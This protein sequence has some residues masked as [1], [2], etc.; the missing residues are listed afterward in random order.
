MEA[1]EAAGRGQQKGFFGRV[2]AAMG[3]GPQDPRQV[4]ASLEME[5]SSL[6]RL[7]Q[8]L[9]AGA[10]AWLLSR[11]CRGCLRRMPHCRSA[12]SCD[13]LPPPSLLPP[14]DVVDLRREHQRALLARTALGH[15]Q[16]LLGYVLSLYCIYR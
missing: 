9:H 16:N 7:R 13:W 3:G 5:V 15:L 14:P 6:D 11:C 1:Q 2:L 4:L 8:A 10:R 12:S